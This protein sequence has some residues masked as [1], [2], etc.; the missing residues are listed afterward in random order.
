MERILQT[1]TIY[2]T[3]SFVFLVT[4]RGP[5]RAPIIIIRYCAKT[6]RGIGGG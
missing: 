5:P 3:V 1:C 6:N 4:G 2:N